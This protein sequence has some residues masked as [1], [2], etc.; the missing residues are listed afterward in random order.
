MQTHKESQHKQQADDGRVNPEIFAKPGADTRDHAIALTASQL[1]VVVVHF[2]LLSFSTSP[3]KNVTLS[4]PHLR[5]VQ[6]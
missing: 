1:F 5:C 6:V 2:L 3:L 4:D